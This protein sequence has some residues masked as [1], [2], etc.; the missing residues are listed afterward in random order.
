MARETRLCFDGMEIHRRGLLREVGDTLMI[1][2]SNCH[3]AHNQ[4][5]NIKLMFQTLNIFFNLICVTLVW[6]QQVVIE[7]RTQLRGGVD[8]KLR[9][10]H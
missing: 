10:V 5:R 9:L 6:W 4:P 7:R 1:T 2:I 8:S 3:L